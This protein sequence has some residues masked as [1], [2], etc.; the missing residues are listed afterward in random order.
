MQGQ[1]AFEQPLLGWMDKMTDEQKPNWGNRIILMIFG[2]LAVIT[3]GGAIWATT[4][5]W[6]A[7]NFRS[8]QEA[9][10]RAHEALE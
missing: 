5:E 9:A 8:D 2:T 4:T 1:I 10:E 6:D 7:G 3:I